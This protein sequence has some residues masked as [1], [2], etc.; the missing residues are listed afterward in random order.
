MSGYIV[1]VDD[2]L[3]SQLLLKRLLKKEGYNDVLL[4]QS[5]EDAFKILKNSMREEGPRIDLILL[6]IIMPG[7]DGIE[8]CKRIKADELT[9]DIPIIMVTGMDKSVVLEQAFEA[10]AMD[11]VKKPFDQLEIKARIQSALRLKNEMEQ[12]KMR[13]QELIEVNRELISLNQF[14]EQLSMV[15]GLT[16]ISNRRRFDEISEME[17]LRAKRSNLEMA[18]LLLDIDHFKEFNDTYGHLE[19][20][21]CLKTVAEMLENN[22]QRTTDLV[23]R[24]GGEEFVVVLPDTTYDGALYVAEKLRKATEMLRIPNENSQVSPYLTMSIG[25]AFTSP[26]KDLITLPEFIQ[27]SDQ[28]LYESKNSGRN[29]VTINNIIERGN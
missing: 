13:E 20:D 1:I 11:Y 25:V 24:Y 17:W 19:G 5:A 15:D 10:G 18:I 6:D 21:E 16:G 9:M 7:M 23:A 28:A 26:A 22:V 27:K 14:L 2:S 8:I 4:A 3:D 12:R 29:A